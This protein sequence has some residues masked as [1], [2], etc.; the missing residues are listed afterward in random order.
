[1]EFPIEEARQIFGIAKSAIDMINR[2][3]DRLNPSGNSDNGDPDDNEDRNDNIKR[4]I[5]ILTQQTQAKKSIHVERFVERTIENP[6]CD[7]EDAT[8]FAFLKDIE[9]LTWRQLCLLEGFR[10][11]DRNAIEIN[12]Y[13]DSGIDGI[14]RTA[15]L[16]NLIH[17]NYLNDYASR[18]F[19][20]IH[21]TKMGQEISKLLDLQSVELSEI[22]KAFGRGRI[23]ETVRY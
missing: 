4:A 6:D 3:R 16:R 12:S 20:R 23:Q 19:E 15:D 10:R 17:L 5:S 22:G 1:M 18:G 7:L 8:I 2:L 11:K 14:S 21:I 13:D 9:Q